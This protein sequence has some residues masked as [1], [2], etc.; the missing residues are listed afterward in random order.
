M[1]SLPMVSRMSRGGMQVIIES[2]RKSG[3][4]MAWFHCKGVGRSTTTPRSSRILTR[5]SRHS[6]PR[7]TVARGRRPHMPRIS[8]S[9]GTFSEVAGSS[10]GMTELSQRPTITRFSGSQSF[11]ELTIFAMTVSFREVG[12]GLST[13]P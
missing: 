7:S 6:L 1:I 4:P 2:L 3:V 5:F 13:S 9:T 11:H 12:S 8:E 10:G